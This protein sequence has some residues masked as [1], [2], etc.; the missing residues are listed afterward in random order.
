M[1]PA[2]VAMPC[3]NSTIMF[4][5]PHTRI[6]CPSCPAYFMLSNTSASSDPELRLFPNDWIAN[7]SANSQK[8][9]EK[10]MMTHDTAMQILLRIMLFF[11]PIR[12]AT[13]PEGI[14]NTMLVA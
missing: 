4:S 8:L 9:L 5:L 7:P 2:T 6:Y 11:L 14:S 12:S 1:P 3:D 10:S 13:A